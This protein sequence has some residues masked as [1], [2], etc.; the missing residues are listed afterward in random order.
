MRLFKNVFTEAP[1]QFL[2]ETKSF[3]RGLLKALRLTGDHQKCFRKILKFFFFYFLFKVFRWERMGFLLFSVG[4]EWFSRLTRIPSGIFGAVKLMKFL[5]PFTLG[6]P[7]E[8]AYL[9]FFKSSQVFAKHGFASVVK[10]CFRRI[11]K[12][13]IIVSFRRCFKNLFQSNLTHIFGTLRIFEFLIWYHQIA[14]TELHFWNVLF[15][16][17]CCFSISAKIF[18][19]F[20]SIEGN[21]WKI[22]GCEY[23]MN[24]SFFLAWELGHY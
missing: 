12:S 20:F 6:F 13:T 2:Q 8:I 7:Y 9:V 5:S 10:T 16:F 4:E 19:V 1:A 14:A 23:A 11:L 24:F 21:S 22:I 3:A 15:S 18:P 17:L